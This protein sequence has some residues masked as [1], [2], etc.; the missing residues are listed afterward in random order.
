VKDGGLRRL[1]SACFSVILA[2]IVGAVGVG[3]GG[4]WGYVRTDDGLLWK[5][6]GTYGAVF[7]GAM[8]AL[9]AIAWFLANE[10]TAPKS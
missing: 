7:L 9:M 8:T 4:I 3:V 6:L 1:N 2:A 10:E 5:L